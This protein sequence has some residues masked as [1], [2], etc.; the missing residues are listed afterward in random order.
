MTVAD[1]GQKWDFAQ[2]TVE[3]GFSV[4]FLVCSHRSLVRSSSTAVSMSSKH[5][6]RV[7]DLGE[8]WRGGVPIGL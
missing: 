4:L 6:I 1:S 8:K 5:D 3:I 2:E 7:G